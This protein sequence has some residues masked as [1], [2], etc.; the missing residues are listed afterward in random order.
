MLKNFLFYGSA[1]AIGILF[2]DEIC[3]FFCKYLHLCICYIKI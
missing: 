2:S 3:Y 1:I